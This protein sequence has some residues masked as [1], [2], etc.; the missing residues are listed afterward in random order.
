MAASLTALPQIATLDAEQ[1]ARLAAICS[2]DPG[3][4]PV[5]LAAWM[6]DVR[7]AVVST[8]AST[9]QQAPQDAAPRRY[10][11]PPPAAAPLVPPVPSARPAVHPPPTPEPV[12]PVEYRPAYAAPAPAPEARTTAQRSRKRGSVLP[13]P[14]SVSLTTLRSV[15]NGDY[16]WLDVGNGTV[17]AKYY[18]NALVAGI[19][20]SSAHKTARLTISADGKALYTGEISLGAPET[21]NLKLDNALR[22][23][24]SYADPQKRCE[25]GRLV[26]GEPTLAK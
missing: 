15:A 12:V 25:M 20:D 26:L 19:D 23:R 22:L 18:E 21:L 2:A 10:V 13:G 11:P 9:S 24:I 3:E 5:S 16:A 14:S 6:K 1:R 17:K 4:R 7:R 8:T